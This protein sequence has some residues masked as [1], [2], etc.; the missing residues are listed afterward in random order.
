MSLTS[1]TSSTEAAD[2]RHRDPHA[3]RAA[4]LEAAEEIFVEKGFADASVSQIARAAGV[5]KSLI[6]HHFG[7]KEGLW[8]E[9]KQLR[10]SEYAT[11]QTRLLEAS[12]L[13]AEVMRQ[14]VEAYFRFLQRHPHFTRLVS[15]THLEEP[16]AAFQPSEDLTSIGIEKI[17]QAQ[18][19]GELRGDIHPFFILIAFIGLSQHWFQSKDHLCS[20]AQEN[21]EV[22]DDE[23]Y[24]DAMLKIFFEGILPSRREGER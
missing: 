14:S 7:S 15:W 3:T 18:Q 9:V 19:A 1:P 12:G 13:D 24:L 17:R 10:F 8:S 4:I 22:R 23:R 11:A 21:H 6:H 20:W 16:N 5:T 2:T